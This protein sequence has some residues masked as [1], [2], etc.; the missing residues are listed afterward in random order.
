MEHRIPQAAGERVLRAAGQRL[1][2]V[3]IDHPAV[4]PPLLIGAVDR[5]LQQPGANRSPGPQAVPGLPGPQDSLAHRVLRVGVAVQDAP[6]RPEHAVAV[7]GHRRSKFLPRRR[8]A[9]AVSGLFHVLTSSFLVRTPY[10][11]MGGRFGSL[12]AQKK[13]GGSPAGLFCVS[14]RS[15]RRTDPPA[16]RRSTGAPGR[17]TPGPPR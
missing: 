3:G 5:N 17:K 8:P 6:G 13:P 12:S 16:R 15:A 9:R 14:F 1:Q 2:L 11:C 7:L 10:R 4:P